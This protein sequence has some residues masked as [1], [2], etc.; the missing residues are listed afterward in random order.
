MQRFRNL[1]LFILYRFQQLAKINNFGLYRDDGLAIASN[2][3]GPH[4][5]IVKKELQVLFKKFGLKL[6]IECSKTTVDCLDITS[7]KIKRKRS[8]IWFKSLFSKTVS[9]KFIQYFLTPKYDSLIIKNHLT[10]STIK[11]FKTELSKKVWNPKSTN[12][13]AK[14]SWKIVRR[15][16]PVNRAILRCNLCF[17]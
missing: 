4:S 10:I 9:T 7:Y 2:M 8:I 11:T 13:H 3:S 12:K 16:T 14:I 17:V 1:W 5:K 15:C 6:I